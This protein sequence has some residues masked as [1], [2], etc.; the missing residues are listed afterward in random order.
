VG[1]G[2]ARVATSLEQTNLAFHR[3]L[4]DIDFKFQ[5]GTLN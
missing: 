4:R 5:L 3:M 2:D 1:R